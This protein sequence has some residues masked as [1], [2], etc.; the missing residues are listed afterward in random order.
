MAGVF[1]PVQSN[2]PSSHGRNGWG[3]KG[4]KEYHYSRLQS[5]NCPQD[6]KEVT[7]RIA[8]IVVIPG[9][10]HELF[11]GDIEFFS[12]LLHVA[13]YEGP[14]ML[15]ERSNTV[16]KVKISRP[17][18]IE[19]CEKKTFRLVCHVMLFSVARPGRQSG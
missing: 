3:K 1:I 4:M 14:V 8:E 18:R 12:G 5:L 13:D 16:R 11:F 15:P 2:G 9:Q 17:V 10:L 19:P 7:K 6:C